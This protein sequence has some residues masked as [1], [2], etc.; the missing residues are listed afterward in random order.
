VPVPPPLPLAALPHGHTARRPAGHIPRFVS[1][2]VHGARSALHVSGG[3]RRRVTEAG[4]HGRMATAG[5][6]PRRHPGTFLRPC[7]SSRLRLQF[8]NGNCSR[9]RV[10]LSPAIEDGR[11]TGASCWRFLLVR[12]PWS[13][14][15]P[16]LFLATNTALISSKSFSLFR[17]KY[18]Q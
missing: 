3:G 16:C 11:E 5:A 1:L 13:A 10:Y 4:G 18:I 8:P 14:L 9:S 17:D 7:L 12:S 15:L 2:P 6:Q